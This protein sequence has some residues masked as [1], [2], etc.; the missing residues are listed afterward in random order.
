MSWSDLAEFL[1]EISTVETVPRLLQVGV[2]EARPSEAQQGIPGQT[3]QRVSLMIPSGDLLDPPLRLVVRGREVRVIGTQ[4][5]PFMGAPSLVTC[6][7]VNPDLPDEVTITEA[8]GPPVLDVETGLY[9][10]PVATLWSGPAYVT[11]GVPATVDVSGE[12]SPLD[13]VTIVIPPVAPYRAD[14]RV[15]VTI[16][17]APGLVGA[18]FKLSGEVLDSGA[19]LRRVVGYRQGA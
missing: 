12:V 15:E 1:E 18:R 9:V 16:S 10:A 14:L 13:K 4:A 17:R 2:S 19:A 6:E 11:S 5:P 7:R 8:T 3:S